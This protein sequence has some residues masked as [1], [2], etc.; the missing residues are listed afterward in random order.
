MR[1]YE[2]KPET[3]LQNKG[4]FTFRFWSEMQAEIRVRDVKLFLREGDY[5]RCLLPKYHFRLSND[6]QTI[7]MPF[8]Q[9]NASNYKAI[10]FIVEIADHQ[11]QE[12]ISVS[13][14]TQEVKYKNM[15]WCE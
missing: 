13:L 8:K 15:I 3:A 4:A 6:F 11:I 7:R 10:T 1:I 14:D 2:C 12:C 9:K 5:E